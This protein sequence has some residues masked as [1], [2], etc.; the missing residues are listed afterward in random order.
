M[1]CHPLR[2]AVSVAACATALWACASTAS[3]E[4]ITFNGLSGE[5]AD[6]LAPYSEAGF[7][8]TPRFGAWKEGH[9]SGNPIPSVYVSDLTETPFG[10]LEIVHDEGLLFSFNS[11]DL[12]VFNSAIGYEIAGWIGTEQVFSV[13]DSQGT[14]TGFITIGTEQPLIDRLTIDI[15]GGGPGS[16]NVDNI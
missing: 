6:P 1:T 9:V 8:V 2:R 10:S 5:I 3:A 13:A 4:I 15:G 12:S 14:T 11:V 7:T 16:F